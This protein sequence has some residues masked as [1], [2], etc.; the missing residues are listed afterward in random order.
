MG[1]ADVINGEY[2]LKFAFFFLLFVLTFVCS[3]VV[4]YSGRTTI[5][6]LNIPR[7]V[8]ETFSDK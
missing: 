3:Y 2:K 6:Y 8:Y 7:K 4:D 5:R 1:F